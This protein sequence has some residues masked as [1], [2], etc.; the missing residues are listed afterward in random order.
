MLGERQVVRDD[1]DRRARLAVQ[2]V[3]ERDDLLA[4]GAVE[5]PGGL[6]GEEDARAVHEGARDRDALLL[7]A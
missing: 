2:L 6:V 1:D 4:R 7:A 3:E 5:V